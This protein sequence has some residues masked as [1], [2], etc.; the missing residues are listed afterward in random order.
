MHCMNR[1]FRALLLQNFYASTGARVPSNRVLFLG[2][3]VA[4]TDEANGREMT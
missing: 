4:A 2:A 1:H 3:D